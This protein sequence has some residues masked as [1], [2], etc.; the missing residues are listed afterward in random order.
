MFSVI[1]RRGGSAAPEILVRQHFFHRVRYRIRRER[2]QDH[3]RDGQQNRADGHD[4]EKRAEHRS[5]TVAGAA[6]TASRTTAP[7]GRL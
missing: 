2:A 5:F 4:D 3:P 7:A 1:E 6:A